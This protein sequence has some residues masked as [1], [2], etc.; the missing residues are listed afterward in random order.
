[1]SLTVLVPQP[2][3]P[4]RVLPSLE[5]PGRPSGR[6]PGGWIADLA[7]DRKFIPLCPFCRAKFDARANQYEPW[8]SR[9]VVIAKCDGCQRVHPRCVGFIPQAYHDEIGDWTR[10]SRRGRWASR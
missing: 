9:M 10:P 3:T 5:A 2:E 7:G 8:R 6:V 4:A 1:M